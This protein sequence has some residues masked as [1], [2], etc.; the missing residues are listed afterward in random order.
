MPGSASRFYRRQPGLG[1]LLTVIAVPLLLAL[2]GWSASSRPEETAA[3]L[4]PT[5]SPPTTPT[6]AA[7]PAA[8]FG[9][10]SVVRSGN[11]FTLT[12]ELPDA[13]SKASLLESLRQALPGAKIV[14][15]LTVARGVAGPEFAGLGGL[16]GAALETPGF[17]ATLRDGTVTLA[18]TAFSAA[19]RAAA[20]SAAKATWPNATV[21]NDIGLVTGTCSTLQPDVTALLKEPINF[22]TD[23]FTLEPDSKKVV[24]QVAAKLESCPG[25]KVAVVGYTDDTGADASNVA[26]SASRANSVATALVADGVP[27]AAVTSRGAG[28][29]NPVAGNDTTAGRA[30]NRRVEII[31]S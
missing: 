17:S 13:A 1:W 15:Q 20:E 16:F 7:P 26:L 19:T 27:R 9:A 6:V 11:G 12:G 21:V 8:A 22:A 10:M 4:A 14:D 3:A 24:G 5:A 31:V 30:E 2:I 28:A 18:G 29:S 23:G 25:A